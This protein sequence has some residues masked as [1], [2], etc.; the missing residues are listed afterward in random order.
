MPRYTRWLQEGM[1]KRGH[2]TEVWSPAPFF[3]RL[4][5]PNTFK[6]WLG[7]LDQYL[8]FPRWV[9]KKVKHLSADTLFVFADHALGPWVPLVAKRLHLIHCH[10]FLA[11]QSALGQ[12]PENKTGW[13]GRQYQSY[14]R[15]GYKMGKNFISVSYKTQQDLHHFLGYTPHVSE[16]VYNGVNPLYNLTDCTDARQQL[17]SRIKTTIEYGYLLHVGGNQWYK[18]RKSIILLYNA[19]RSQT[20][21]PLPLLLIGEKPDAFLLETYSA[22][23]YQKD[24]YFLH[25]LEDIYV[26]Y[27]Y[28]GAT[29]F[30]FPSLAEGFGWPIAEAMACGC[31]VITTSCP[32]MNEVGADAAFYLEKM[33]SDKTEV[34]AW[35]QRS[36]SIIESVVQLSAMERQQAVIRGLDSVRRFDSNKALDCIEFIYKSILTPA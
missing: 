23:A 33:P 20:N 24:I 7:Y 29:A 13:T 11:Q 3:I 8:V 26:K 10:D 18:N 9:K 31:L 21:L 22:S 17:A 12:I 35:A 2:T 32:P 25:G 15:N 36:A 28:A 6:K 1:A 19:W 5:T 27:A 34:K 14:I 30:L 16:V 4:P